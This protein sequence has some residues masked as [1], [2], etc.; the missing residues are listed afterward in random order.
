[1]RLASRKMDRWKVQKLYFPMVSFSRPYVLASL[2]N[3]GGQLPRFSDQ[4]RLATTKIFLLLVIVLLNSRSVDYLQN[5]RLATTYSYYL[6]GGASRGE[7][8]QRES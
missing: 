4:T 8:N 6:G 2:R 3:R 7:G 5:V 1:M